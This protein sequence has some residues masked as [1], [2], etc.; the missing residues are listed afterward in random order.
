[1]INRRVGSTVTGMIADIERDAANQL[2]IEYNRQWRKLGKII[3]RLRQRGYPEDH[4]LL[5]KATAAEQA[6]G[7][8]AVEFGTS[9]TPVAQRNERRTALMQ[10]PYYGDQPA[11]GVD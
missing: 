9:A 1:M 2:D 3:A 5:T 10:M 6:V 7:A 4:P 11:K 8:L